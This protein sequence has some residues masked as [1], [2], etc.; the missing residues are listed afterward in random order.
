MVIKIHK[1]GFSLTEILVAT[2]VMT[3][4]MTG[5][6]GFV[7]YGG[8][9]WQKGQN[10]INAKNYSNMAFQLLKDDLLQAEAVNCPSEAASSSNSL[11]YEIGSN[12][13]VIKIEEDLTLT[14]SLDNTTRS[15]SSARSTPPIT[16][17]IRIARNVKNFYVYR[18]S[19]WTFE[20]GLQIQSSENEDE[21]GNIIEPEIISSESVVLLAPG[22]E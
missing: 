20:I 13:Y 9:I 19:T 7:Q 3:M 5:V 21:E 16:K 2:I 14:K 15:S 22:V 4:I 1:R 10:K 17:P 6:L 8:E 12:K 11:K 18:V